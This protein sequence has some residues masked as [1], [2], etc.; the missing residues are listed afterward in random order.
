[1][2]LY[3]LTASATAYRRGL[4]LVVAAQLAGRLRSGGRRRAEDRT[5][6][7]CPRRPGRRAARATS[8]TR[9]RPTFRCAPLARRV[10]PRTPATADAPSCTDSCGARRSRTARWGRATRSTCRTCSGTST[11]RA[12]PTFAG[13]DGPRRGLLS[14]AADRRVDTPSRAAEIPRTPASVPGRPTTPARR[15]TLELWRALRALRGGAAASASARRWSA[16][17]TAEPSAR[18]WRRARRSPSLAQPR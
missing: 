9:S 15:A 5:R 6:A 17:A 10:A 1:M 8:S 14:D 11:R 2:R 3:V 12:C 4:P 16:L 18:G 7:R 13:G